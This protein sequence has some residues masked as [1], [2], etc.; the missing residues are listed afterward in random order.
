MKLLYP[1]WKK[2]GN[3]MHEGNWMLRLSSHG[4]QLVALDPFYPTTFHDTYADDF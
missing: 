3:D 1:Y 4:P 2:Y